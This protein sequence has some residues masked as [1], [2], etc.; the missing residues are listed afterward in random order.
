[1]KKY[2]LVLFSAFLIAACDSQRVF[3]KNIEIPNKLWRT[4]SVLNFEFEINSTRQRF[5]LYYNVR[6]SL[7]YPFQNLYVQCVVQD[8]LGNQ[9]KKELINQNLFD[10][11][12]G[13][14]YGSGLGDV[15]DHQ[16]LILENYKFNR[17]GTYKVNIKHYMRPDTLQ[18][19]MAVGVRLEKVK[20]E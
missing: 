18:E 4:D 2:F 7:S 15:F 6:N 10:P 17:V 19:I 5:N 13:R 14:P 8:T 3:E 16:F 1:M 11:K 9:V 20:E 12:T